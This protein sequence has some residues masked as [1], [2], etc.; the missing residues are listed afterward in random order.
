MI[1]NVLYV[2]TGR[3]ALLVMAAL[4]LLF[5]FRQ[6]G[7]KGLIGGAAMG[8]LIA[9][10]AWISSPYFR[11][12][13]Q[14]TYEEVETYPTYSKITSTWLHMELLKKSGIIVAEAPVTGHGTGSILE[15][16]RRTVRGDDDT[17][18][19]LVS[20]NPHNQILAVA[21]QLGLIGAIIL[22]TMWLAHLVLFR[23]PGLVTWL[24]LIVV[25]QNIVSSLFN[26][27]IA[28]FGQ[29][30]LYVFG[31]GVTGGMTL[32]SSSTSIKDLKF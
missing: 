27:H 14:L 25:S 1:A 7:S 10:L 5:G 19:A 21:I 31:V 12:R 30:W 13:V 22:L 2:V 4:M 20:S 16:F 6:F 3:T 9:A 32:S 8:A 17:L 18:S 24:G 15:S 29:G 23:G 11:E 26:S 28:D